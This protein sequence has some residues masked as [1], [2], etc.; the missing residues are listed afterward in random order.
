MSCALELE[1]VFGT[2]VPMSYCRGVSLPTHI[3]YTDD[4]LICCIGMKKNVRCLLRVFTCY[5]EALGR[6]VNFDKRKLFNGAMTTTRI[7]M[8]AHMSGFA[9]G[10]IPFY[11]LVSLF[12]RVSLFLFLFIK[13]KLATWK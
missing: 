5:Y 7:H 11:Y 3:L 10:S 4:V 13:V 12:F 8:L 9:A 6:L 1:R 2:L